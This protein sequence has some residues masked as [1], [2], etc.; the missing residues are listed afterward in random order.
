[1][2]GSGRTPSPERRPYEPTPGVL[3]CG[4]DTA[5]DGLR[6]AKHLYWHPTEKTWGESTSTSEGFAPYTLISG[7][8]ASWGW[9]CHIC[10]RRDYNVAATTEKA[11]ELAHANQVSAHDAKG[12]SQVS[13]S[14]RGTSPSS[15]PA[16]GE[17]A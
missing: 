1:M 12:S 11:D 7:A 16:P 4:C 6:C 17:P 3:V 8:Y 10:K 15:S 14:A 5:S 9:S 2:S 13:E